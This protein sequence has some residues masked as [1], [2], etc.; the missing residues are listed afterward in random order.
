MDIQ[1][2]RIANGQYFE[3]KNHWAGAIEPKFIVMHYTATFDAASAIATL[4]DN[5][6]QENRGR[7][8]AHIVADLNGAITQLVPFNLAAWHA[9]PSSYKPTD[10]PQF[11]DLNR[12][13]IGIEI[14]NPG[15]LTR[16]V[17][18]HYF[19][20]AGHDV[21]Q[22][23]EGF[24]GVVEASEPFVGSASYFWPQYPEAQL[25]AVEEL[26]RAL[27]AK[28]PSIQWIVGHRDIRP[29]HQ[30]VDPGPAFPMARFKR[31]VDDRARGAEISVPNAA[32]TPSI[33]TGAVSSPQPPQTTP[34]TASS[35]SPAQAPS[36]TARTQSL[37]NRAQNT[38]ARLSAVIAFLTGA[39]AFLNS[40]FGQMRA[41]IDQFRLATSTWLH[42]DP[43]WIVAAIF[44]AAILFIIF[45]RIERRIENR[46]ERRME[47]ARTAHA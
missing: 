33:E 16:N 31:L 23:L 11:N 34:P 15:Y 3:S 32:S 35:T 8:S 7:T 21:T 43:I 38:G 28:F 20:W 13:S 45:I 26:T 37:P 25:D 5:S 19:N 42:F 41:S 4:T 36:S 44:M 18:G 10:G 39:I 6:R 46:I 14:V 24:P 1:D 30:K 29:D 9:G 47:R 2:N 17:A 12:H 27:L 22:R 40:L